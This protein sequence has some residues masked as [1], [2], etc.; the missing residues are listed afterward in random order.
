MARPT[1]VSRRRSRLD[2]TIDTS[3]TRA[4]TYAVSC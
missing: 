2:E 3:M 1:S 4:A